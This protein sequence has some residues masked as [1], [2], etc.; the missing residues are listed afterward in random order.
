MFLFP[1]SCLQL[2][3]SL[4]FVAE[5]NPYSFL[6][7]KIFVILV[8]S[9]VILAGTKILQGLA[10]LQL[11]GTLHEFLTLLKG[12]KKNKKGNKTKTG[13]THASCQLVSSPMRSQASSSLQ[14]SHIIQI[15]L[16]LSAVVGITTKMYGFL[17]F[18][19]L[20]ITLR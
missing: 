14:L 10:C 5:I 6:N 3:A 4:F 1:V 11:I 20:K 19:T 9:I 15:S 2:L 7:F 12:I 8:L 13:A 17:I 16:S 18:H